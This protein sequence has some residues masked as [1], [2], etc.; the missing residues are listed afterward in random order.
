MNSWLPRLH[1][2]YKQRT[3]AYPSCGIL[4]RWAGEIDT[5]V[6]W[7]CRCAGI[8][9]RGWETS[10]SPVLPLGGCCILPPFLFH[11]CALSSLS[12]HGSDSW[13]WPEGL[14][15]QLL[16][17]L[18]TGLRMEAAGLGRHTSAL[19]T[20]FC[21]GLFLAGVGSRIP[22]T[23]VDL[24]Y[25]SASQGNLPDSIFNLN[26]LIFVLFFYPWR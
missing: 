11:Y 3:E 24:K 26:F 12:T 14:F 2:L 7:L 8:G 19:E 13:C 20:T 4:L 10:R 9:E 5:M 17:R 15:S 23:S 21:L 18:Q 16:Q 6:V 1:I 25:L 22:L